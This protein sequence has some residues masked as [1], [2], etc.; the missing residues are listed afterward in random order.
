MK[1]FILSVLLLVI[2]TLI[3]SQGNKKDKEASGSQKDVKEL[4]VKK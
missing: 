2:A 3:F 1:K 4:V